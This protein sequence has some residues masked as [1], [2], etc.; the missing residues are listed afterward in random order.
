M[1]DKD[2]E[3]QEFDLES[4]MK[5]FGDGSAPEEKKPET[6]E[7]APEELPEEIPAAEASAPEEELSEEEPEQILPEEKP[8]PAEEPDA[9]ED[10]P[11]KTDDPEPEKTDDP[12]EGMEGETIRLD[13]IADAHQEQEEE[14][15]APVQPAE[16]EKPEA[17]SEGWEPEYDQPIGEYVPPQP[18]Q[19][20][21]HSRLR[22]LKKKLI[23]GPEKRYY[24]LA[25]QG[26][27]RIQ[28]LIFLNLLV[29]LLS[30]GATVMNAFHFIPEERF[31]LLVFGQFFA[32]MLSA[33]FGSFQLI[34]GVGDLF[35]GRFTWNTMLVFTFRQ[36]GRPGM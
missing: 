21:P 8:E 16:P 17:F 5:E 35:H 10:S 2:Q 6:E 31:K 3:L 7:T 26:T 24:E 4:I 15:T 12:E 32:L 14:K 27:G 18:I 1:D 33:L 30:V 11:E 19:F 29:V 20:H 28:A 34:D 36:P 23:A 13:A 9:S 25:E 22:E